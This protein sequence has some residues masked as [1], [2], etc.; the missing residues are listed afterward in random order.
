MNEQVEVGNVKEGED[1]GAL[2][3]AKTVHRNGVDVAH[4]VYNC[5]PHTLD[6]ALKYENNYL[7]I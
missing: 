2:G 6:I 4:G 5:Y 3:V 7:N 1:Y